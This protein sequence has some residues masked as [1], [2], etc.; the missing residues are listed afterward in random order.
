MSRK[1]TGQSLFFLLKEL[2]NKRQVV[3]FMFSFCLS[4]RLT[5][6][7]KVTRPSY[8]VKVPSYFETVWYP[9]LYFDLK[10]NIQHIEKSERAKNDGNRDSVLIEQLERPPQTMSHLFPL[11]E[12]EKVTVAGWHQNLKTLICLFFH[13]GSCYLRHQHP[14]AYRGECFKVV[15]G[16]KCKAC[17]IR[18]IFQFN[19]F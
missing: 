13:R 14:R 2:K 9:Y 16:T 8:F 19:L 4:F 12:K 1:L 6:T 11:N 17:S 15:S 3:R 5:V 18:H 7:I 10:S